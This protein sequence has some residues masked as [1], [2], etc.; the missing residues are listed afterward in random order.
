MQRTCWYVL[1]SQTLQGKKEQCSLCQAKG[2]KVLIDYQ[3][4]QPTAY[5]DNFATAAS[6]FLIYFLQIKDSVAS[7]PSANF[8]KREN[9]LLK[10]FQLCFQVLTGQKVLQKSPFSSSRKQKE[11]HQTVENILSPIL[12]FLILDFIL[13]YSNYF[14][15]SISI[16]KITIKPSLALVRTATNNTYKQ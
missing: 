12:K 3:W 5:A 1:L 13:T 9:H 11:A 4:I 2:N 8:Q 10:G 7:A 14:I 6:Q 16:H 15:R